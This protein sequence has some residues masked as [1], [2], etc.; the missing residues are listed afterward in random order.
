MTSDSPLPVLIIVF[1]PE[2]P[3]TQLTQ[4][5]LPRQI[6]LALDV[7]AGGLSGHRR[8]PMTTFSGGSLNRDPKLKKFSSGQATTTEDEL[9]TME[10][11]ARLLFSYRGSSRILRFHSLTP[12]LKLFRGKLRMLFDGTGGKEVILGE[13][14]GTTSPWELNR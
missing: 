10:L 13:T 12:R 3:L 4:S 8:C 7:R 2:A 6:K 14:V 11:G 1:F 5:L 9:G